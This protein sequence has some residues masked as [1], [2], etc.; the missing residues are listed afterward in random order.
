MD[1]EKYIKRRDELIERRKKLNYECETNYNTMTDIKKAIYEDKNIKLFFDMFMWTYDPR[2]LQKPFKQMILWDEQVDY[3]MWLES[4]LSEL[5]SG[6]NEKSRDMGATW[7][8]LGW[9]VFH[10]LVDEGFSATLGSRKED[11]VDKSGD[12]DS[13]FE[14]VRFIIDYLPRWLLP[15]N[16]DPNKH[17]RFLRITNP[18]NGAMIRGESANKNFGRASRSTVCLLDEF[19]FWEHDEESH[20][21]ASQV[22]QVRVYLSSVDG[23]NNCFA[24]LRWHSDIDV[25]IMDWKDHPFKS[26]EWY[27]ELIRS[28]EMTLQQIASEIDRDYQAS[29]GR[30]F[31]PEFNNR[32][33]IDKCT[34]TDYKMLDWDFGYHHPACGF[35]CKD[36]NE[37]ATKFY[38][39]MGNDIQLIE[40]IIAVDYVIGWD[41][42]E[43][44]I[45]RLKDLIAKN[46]FENIKDITQLKVFPG[47]YNEYCDDAGSQV[48]DKSKQTSIDILNS[49]GH[50]PRYKQSRV[51]EGANA[52]RKLMMKD[53]FRITKDC[54]ISIEALQ[55]GYHFRKD[56]KHANEP[57]KDGYYEHP[58]DADREMIV[59]EY[60][61]LI[62]RPVIKKEDPYEKMRDRGIPH[63]MIEMIREGRQEMK[64]DSLEALRKKSGGTGYV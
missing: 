24:R 41:I 38:E 25:F 47:K 59:H 19:A 32:M 20:Q 31:Y 50:H 64:K 15:V 39:L 40:F 61:Y 51:D 27:D 35:W 18:N 56:P 21:S 46:K 36:S 13:L 10:W 53:M 57:E 11:C 7:I 33:I 28:G 49:A 3:L 54:P 23:K 44:K 16:Y 5:K 37:H 43:S 52:W 2:D 17:D 48:S 22:S 12:M 55:G 9:I 42:G 34:P 1:K 45:N 4:R 63:P 14:R 26:Q 30:A 60:S 62:D 58:M 29:S 8:S 6:L